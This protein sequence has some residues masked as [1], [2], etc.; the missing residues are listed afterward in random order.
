MAVRL[1]LPQ[2]YFYRHLSDTV[3]YDVDSKGQQLTCSCGNGGT[4]HAKLREK[5]DT[6]NKHRV[7]DNI[8]NTAA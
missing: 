4:S 6:E 8:C 2:V 3:G 5:A 7:K 1:W